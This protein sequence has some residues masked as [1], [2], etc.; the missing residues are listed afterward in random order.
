MKIGFIGAGNMATA[1]IKGICNKKI[2]SVKDLYVSNR[3]EAKLTK[4][5]KEFG[6]KTTTNN[7]DVAKKSDILFLCVKP[8]MLD[9]VIPEIAKFVN[10][11]TTIV[12]IAA[13]KTIKYLE[14]TFGKEM[15]IVRVMPNTPALIGEGIS[16]V[17]LN[18]K[19]KDNKENFKVIMN[20]LDCLG[21]SEIV[22]ED[23]I[24]IIGQIAGA[25]PAWISMIVEGMVDGAVYEGM[26]R[27]MAYKF[28]SAGVAGAGK[29]ALSIGG[30]PAVIKDMCS[31]PKG[32]T[33]EGIRV[34]ETGGVRGDF[35]NAVIASCEKSK[36]M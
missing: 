13:G 7:V 1:I 6:I 19:A 31:S 17:C 15:E 3:S 20:I 27:E 8:Q 36:K 34:L 12:S 18:D 16:A 22:N 5:N 4:L 33:I 2:V 35:M 29:L 24:D 21:E 30:N 11:K 32:T 14:N 23:M 28:A 25:S 26:S 10:D 9:T